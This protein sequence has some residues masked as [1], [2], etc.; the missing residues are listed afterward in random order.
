MRIL[1][2][3][4][5]FLFVEIAR[6]HLHRMGH[7]VVVGGVISPVHDAYAKKELAPATHRCSMLRLALQDSDWIRLC[8]WETRQNAWTRT[9]A[10]LQYHQNLLN[11]FLFDTNDVRNN[12]P[13]ED[14]EWI[15]ENIR[16]SEDQTPIQIKLL[17][18]ADL[19]ESFGK[20]DLWMEED[21]SPILFLKYLF[22]IR[23]FLFIQFHFCYTDRYN[24][25]STWT[26][27]CYKRGL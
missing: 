13:E 16:N 19:L 10:S 7:H 6:D 9:R 8:T 15:P 11:L 3:L 24:S 26:S 12:V 5:Y 27:C 20:S 21:V 22:H 18:G 25:W 1:R 4:F 17:C 23:V 2:I 14:L